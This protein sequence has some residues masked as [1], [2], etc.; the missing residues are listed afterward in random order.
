MNRTFCDHCG[1]ELTTSTK[2]YLDI[3]YADM[4]SVMHKAKRFYYEFCDEACLWAFFD[5]VKHD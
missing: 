4:G 5:K 1:K 2:A 3:E